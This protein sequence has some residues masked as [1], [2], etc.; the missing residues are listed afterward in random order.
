MR[1]IL[2]PLLL[3]PTILAGCGTGRTQDGQTREKLISSYTTLFRSLDKDH[4]GKLSH[5][6]VGALVDHFMA[7]E[8]QG[9]ARRPPALVLAKQRAQLMADFA[10]EDMDHD[11]YL[12]LAEIL[13]KP[14]AMV[15]CKTADTPRKMGQCLD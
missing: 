13:H 6:E 2:F 15:D 4:D 1:N 5:A 12:T 8:R 14:L 9:S 7:V 11:G 10:S 3:L